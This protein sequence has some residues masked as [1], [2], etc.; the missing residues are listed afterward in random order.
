MN[1]LSQ[2]LEVELPE[3]DA[4]AD[5]NGPSNCKV[6]IHLTGDFWQ[7]IDI[8]LARIQK[9]AKMGRFSMREASQFYPL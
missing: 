4:Q 2:P 6:T 5:L 1:T 7:D 8:F 9:L 3:Q